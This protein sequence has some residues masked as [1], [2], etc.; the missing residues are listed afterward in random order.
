MN[1]AT[2]AAREYL[3]GIADLG[4]AAK[5]GGRV[6]N[7]VN[8]RL[9]EAA[10]PEHPEAMMVPTQLVARA[11]IAR[12]ILNVAADWWASLPGQPPREVCL[13]TL[14]SILDELPPG[15]EGGSYLPQEIVH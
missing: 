5:W 12:G 11:L 14:Q 13:A 15:I 3:L 6:P 1:E 8:D 10:N 4:T 9:N 7:E 2:R